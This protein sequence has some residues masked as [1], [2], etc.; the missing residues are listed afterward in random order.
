MPMQLPTRTCDA[1]GADVPVTPVEG[2]YEFD[3]RCPCGLAGTIS[4]FHGAEPPT[5]HAER[6]GNLFA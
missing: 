3:W 4:W 6:Q 2:G 1:C 5:C